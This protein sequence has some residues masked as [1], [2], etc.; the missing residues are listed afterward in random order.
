[1]ETRIWQHQ[2]DSYPDP[3]TARYKCHKLVYFEEFTEVT[4]ALAREKQLK[5]W[6]RG[7][8]VRLIESTNPEWADLSSRA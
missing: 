1:L 2:N 6:R 7:K 4:D 5:A 3:F 8:K